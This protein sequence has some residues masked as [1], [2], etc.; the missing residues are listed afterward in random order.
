MIQ[1]ALVDRIAA[2]ANSMLTLLGAAEA[3]MGR[4]AQARPS[5]PWPEL[6]A[7]WRRVE[8]ATAALQ[9]L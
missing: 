2:E 3:E 8:A 9:T 5:D 4:A 1:A 7:A 6:G